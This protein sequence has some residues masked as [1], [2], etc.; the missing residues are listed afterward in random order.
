ML[1]YGFQADVNKTEFFFAKET[2]K[3]TKT[4]QAANG[5]EGMKAEVWNKKAGQLWRT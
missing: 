4:P 5:L 2:N 1:L 3:Q